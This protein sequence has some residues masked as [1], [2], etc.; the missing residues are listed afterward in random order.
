ML[1]S[2]NNT[3]TIVIEILLA[4]VLLFYFFSRKK[5]RKH[6]ERHAQQYVEAKLNGVFTPSEIRVKAGYPVE[7]RIHRYSTNP[8]EEYLDI[9]ELKIYEIL[10]ALHTTII[11]FTPGQRGRFPMILGGDRNAGTI[12]VE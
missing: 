11:T 2:Y 9:E 4:A 10:P 5:R 7:L 6:D 3:V 8:L 1:Y 12:F